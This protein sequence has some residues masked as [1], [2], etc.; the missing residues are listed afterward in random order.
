[1]AAGAAEVFN[2][3]DRAEDMSVEPATETDAMNA[4]HESL[5]NT[6][7]SMSRMAER[8]N[9]LA[10]TARAYLEM[11]GRYRRG[12]VSAAEAMGVED[13]LRRAVDAA[14]ALRVGMTEGESQR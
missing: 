8:F 2:M 7:M 9:R 6:E 1:M 12:A 11:I 4:L 13:T 10:D 14:Y 3:G 5:Y